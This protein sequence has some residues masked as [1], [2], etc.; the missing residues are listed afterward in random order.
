MSA[1]SWGRFKLSYLTIIRITSK[2]C[3]EGLLVLP[4]VSTKELVSKGMCGVSDCVDSDSWQA[5][6][7]PS[8]RVSGWPSSCCRGC[9]PGEPRPATRTR[10]SPTR[11]TRTNT[12]WAK[13]LTSSQY[14]AYTMGN[15][16]KKRKMI[17]FLGSHQIS[18]LEQRQQRR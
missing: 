18:T 4:W 15:H 9:S 10:P 1:H 12:G 8:K 13:V 17:A 16:R 5:V 7:L 14:L 2:I 3:T 11:P 6:C